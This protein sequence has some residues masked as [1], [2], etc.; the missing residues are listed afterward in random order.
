ML[1]G[2]QNNPFRVLGVYAN[3]PKKDAVANKG[4]ISA[5]LKVGKEVTF[6]LDLQGILPT[7]QRDADIV[8]N[9]TKWGLG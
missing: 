4:K 8:A 2:I 3:S 6:P 1:K 9:G 7:I 5:F